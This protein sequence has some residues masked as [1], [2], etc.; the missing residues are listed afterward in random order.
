M[1]WPTNCKTAIHAVF[2]TFN[3]FGD[4]Y[5]YVSEYIRDKSVPPQLRNRY[6][7]VPH[8]I[9]LPDIDSDLRSVLGIPEKALVFGYHGG[10]D[11]FN[12]DFVKKCIIEAVENRKDTY[13]IFMNV[14]K[15]YNHDRIM[16][17]E[18]NSD[19]IYKTKFINS[20]N[21]MIH[22]RAI[23]ETFGIACGEFSIRNKPIITYKHGIDTNHI[24]ILKEKAILYSTY[25]DLLYIF[26]NFE[27]YNLPIDWNCYKDFSAEKVM[28]RF[29]EVYIK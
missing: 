28:N 23:G 25:H 19:L 29:K 2:N 17:L 18:G 15:F 11:S 1:L 7:Y 24:G 6:S 8:I 16:F 13:F 5:A 10:R 26:K 21:A 27:D 20:C 12:I 4:V 3:P 14:D 9:D 22:A